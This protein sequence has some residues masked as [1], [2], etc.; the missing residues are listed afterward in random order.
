MMAKLEGKAT[1]YSR[2]RVGSMN[3]M[4]IDKRLMRTSGIIGGFILKNVS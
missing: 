2:S 4:D 3:I 1:G